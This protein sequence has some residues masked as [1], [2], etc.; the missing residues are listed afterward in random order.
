MNYPNQKDNPARQALTHAIDKAIAEGAPV[1]VNEP[2]AAK[3]LVGT[4]V[5]VRG[6]KGKTINAFVFRTFKDGDFRA[7]PETH[8]MYRRAIDWHRAGNTAELL[9]HKVE[10]EY[11]SRVYSMSELREQHTA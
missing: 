9:S 5:A 11:M 7:I 6:E 3:V 2:A 8:T 1:Y 4:V 10:I